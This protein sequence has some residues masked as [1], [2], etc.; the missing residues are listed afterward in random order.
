MLAYKH[1]IIWNKHSD[2]GS[3]E[4]DLNVVC[5]DRNSELAGY[6]EVGYEG[7]DCCIL[8]E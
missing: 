2:Q 5:R 6:A 8:I 4:Q 7:F 3:S 1:T